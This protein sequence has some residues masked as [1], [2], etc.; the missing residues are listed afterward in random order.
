MPVKLFTCGSET[1]I[2]I[3]AIRDY[4]MSMMLLSLLPNLCNTNII[5]T[6]DMSGKTERNILLIANAEQV[7][8]KVMPF[9]PVLP[10]VYYAAVWQI[11]DLS[12]RCLLH[13]ELKTAVIFFQTE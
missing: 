4:C 3:P 1:V 7:Q 2:I 12:V 9:L 6:I 13:I 5:M 11:R 8:Y 10:D